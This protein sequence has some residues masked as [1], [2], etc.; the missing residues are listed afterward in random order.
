MITESD[1]QAIERIARKYNVKKVLLFGSSVYSSGK[2]SD[3]DIGVEGIKDRDFFAF[4]GELMFALS[5]PVDVV[6]LSRKSK[7]NDL[8]VKEG[9]AIYG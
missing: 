6:D 3:I 1:R 8:I 7:F 5:K 4:Y 2:S 9:S